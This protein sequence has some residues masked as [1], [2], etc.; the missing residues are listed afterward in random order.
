MK[1]IKLFIVLLTILS[2]LFVLGTVHFFAA[3]SGFETESLTDE[4]KQKIIKNFDISLIKVEPAKRKIYC[5][6]V[7]SKGM[8]AIGQNDSN[9]KVI[10]I[11]DRDGSFCF[12]YGFECYGTFGIELNEDN[13]LIYLVRDQLTVEINFDGKI[14]N[15]EKITNATKNT[16]YWNHSVFAESKTENGVCYEMKNNNGFFDL[17]ATAYTQISVT[18]ADGEERIIYD[19]DA[20]S[21]QNP[22]TEIIF[23]AVIIACCVFGFFVFIFIMFFSKRR[24]R[25]KRF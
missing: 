15:V 6:D 12:G 5:F 18:E 22:Y 1:K 21:S 19:C 10:S 20:S 4:A 7:N 17:F 3:D 9:N 2:L 24:D 16:S 13:L 14:Q 8:I 23:I 11:F 25:S